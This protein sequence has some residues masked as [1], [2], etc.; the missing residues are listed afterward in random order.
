M[1]ASQTQNLVTKARKEFLEAALLAKDAE[2]SAEAA[3]ALNRQARLKFKQ[4][5]KWARH[6][7][8]LAKK[9]GA[10]AVEAQKALQKAGENLKKAERKALKELKKVQAKTKMAKPAKVSKPPVKRKPVAIAKPRPSQKIMV[11]A[12]AA[13]SDPQPA[14][15]MLDLPIIDP[16]TP[17]APSQPAD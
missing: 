15:D 9:A 16:V 5:K 4:A 2:K 13:S 3:T 11:P 1:K 14:S 10:A 12:P 6:T 17:A 8:K 7:K